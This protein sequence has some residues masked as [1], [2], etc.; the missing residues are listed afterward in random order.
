MKVAGGRVPVHPLAAAVQQ[1]RALRAV[2][3]GL[4][5]GAADGGRARDED[6]LVALADHSQDAL[7]MVL[8]RRR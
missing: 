1:D 2:A 7:A 5:E 6:G 8:A 4:V 3:D